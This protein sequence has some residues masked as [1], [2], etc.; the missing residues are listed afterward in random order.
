MK[1]I[2]KKLILTNFKGIRDLEVSFDEVTT[3]T[4]A[5]ATGKTTIKDAFLWLFFGKDSAGRSDF[6]IKTLDRSGEVLHNM[7][8][9]VHATLEVDGATVTLLK[10]Y[11]EKWTKVRGKPKAEFTGHTTEYFWNGVPF[12]ERDFAVKIADEFAHESLFRLLTDTNYFQTLSKTEQRGELL[13]IAGEITTEE[14]LRGMLP[15]KDLEEI[16]KGTKTIEEHRAEIKSKLKGYETDRVG[17]PARIDELRR[18]LS[19]FTHDYDKLAADLATTDKALSGVELLLA[20]RSEVEKKRGDEILE[21]IRVVNQLKTMLRDLEYKIRDK[22]TE[23]NHRRTVALT[24][25]KNDLRTKLAEKSR[26]TLDLAAEGARALRWEQA[27]ADLVEKWKAIN[28]ETLEFTDDDLNC[29]TCKRPL[30]EEVASTK[31]MELMKNF[32]ADKARRL[33]ETDQA[34]KQ[35]AA[36]IRTSTA[37]INALKIEIQTLEAKVTLLTEEVANLETANEAAQKAETTE[38]LNDLSSVDP[39]VVLLREKIRLAEE[40]IHAPLPDF[41]DDKTREDL[42]SQRLTLLAAANDIRGKLATKV[43]KDRIAERL[44]ELGDKELDISEKIMYLE[45]LDY[46]L[47]LFNRKKMEILEA[48]V[49]QKFSLV[50]FKLFERQINGGLAD[51]CLTLIGGVPYPDA[52]TASKV[53]AGLDIINT[54]SKFYDV[55]APVWIDNRESVISIPETES[56]VINLVVARGVEP[57]RITHSDKKV[58][59]NN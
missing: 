49:N 16:V 26:L 28:A 24:G 56:Q 6:Q 54:L 55:F 35:T 9:S 1:I 34:G 42:L 20:D 30:S 17:L 29:P 41:D 7:D 15:S 57:L 5:N 52:N 33:A 19:S 21:K 14:I 53:T 59:I 2:L 18:S 45:G 40:A 11:R 12:K 46:S 25:K 8:H 58:L 10:T 32:I 47:D 48:R 39:E 38:M 23:Q 43:E 13:A 37:A 51:A 50:S 44:T 22:I 31:R 4:G 3:I 27:K 36:D